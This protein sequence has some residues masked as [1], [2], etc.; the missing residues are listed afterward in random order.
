MAAP[1]R[2]YLFIC[3][4]GGGGRRRPQALVS[5]ALSLGSVFGRKISNK[6]EKYNQQIMYK[7]RAPQNINIDAEMGAKK[8]CQ[9]TL[10]NIAKTSIGQYH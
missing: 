3:F 9:N 10:K 2:D 8:E 1:K 6:H 7:T 5:T 4:F